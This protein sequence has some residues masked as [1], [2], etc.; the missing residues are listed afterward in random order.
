M[1]LYKIGEKEKAYEYLRF[2]LPST[3]CQNGNSALYKNEPYVL[4]ADVYESGEGGWSW[5]TGSSSWLYVVIVEYLFGIKKQADVITFSPLL[6]DK[7]TKAELSLVFDGV[8]MIVEINNEKREGEWSLSCQ[9]VNYKTASLKIC[10]QNRKK[11]TL[12]KC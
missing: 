12:S 2:L 4:S 11:F 1:A 10:S 7:I 5:Y 8:K 9:G 6:P 3:H